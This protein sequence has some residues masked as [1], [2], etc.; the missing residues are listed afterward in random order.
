MK[1]AI[2]TQNFTTVAKHAG[3]TYD[4]LIF[5][6]NPGQELPAP[7][8]ITLRKEQ[9]IHYFD[10]QGPHPLDGAELIV[11][12]SAGDGFIRHMEKRNTQVIQTGESDPVLV[13]EKILSGDE[14]AAP[15]FD[16]T[17]VLCKVHDLFSDH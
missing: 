6:A 5:E 13:V 9:L 10:D 11:T 16:I 12:A 4:W 14:L 15:R 3:K 2:A 17:R 7:Q 1:I 8:R